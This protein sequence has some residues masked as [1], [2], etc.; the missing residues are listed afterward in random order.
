MP[1]IIFLIALF[2]FLS[3][4]YGM[5]GATHI[6]GRVFRWLFK[7]IFRYFPAPANPMPT[8]TAPIPSPTQN[9]LIQLRELH[10]LYQNGGISQEEYEEVKQYLLST[11]APTNAQI[12]K[13]TP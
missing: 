8:Q 7:P 11:I 9:C 12:S 1:F 4:F 3:L 5:A 2:A 10:S 13:G 6:F